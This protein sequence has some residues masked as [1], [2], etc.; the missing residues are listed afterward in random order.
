[1]SEVFNKVDIQKMTE[2]FYLLENYLEWPEII[3]H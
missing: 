3:H 1:M 2:A